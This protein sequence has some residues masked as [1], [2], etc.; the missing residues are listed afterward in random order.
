MGASGGPRAGDA[1]SPPSTQSSRGPLLPL[2]SYLTAG[3]RTAYGT[4]RSRMSSTT[5]WSTA[6]FIERRSAS[7]LRGVQY[8]RRPSRALIRTVSAAVLRRRSLLGAEDP[9]HVHLASETR[10]KRQRGPC[11]RRQGDRRGPP[12]CMKARWWGVLV[13][14]RV[15]LWGPLPWSQHLVV[16]ERSVLGVESC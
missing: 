14:G 2:L 1:A 10:R 15:R 12:G 16:R 3:S 5:R 7:G 6:S 13:Y 11:R 8:E 4:V 9:L